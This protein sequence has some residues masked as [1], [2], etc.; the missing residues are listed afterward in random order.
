MTLLH[1]GQLFLS[2]KSHQIP[3][4]SGRVSMVGRR[5]IKLSLC[6]LSGRVSMGGRREIT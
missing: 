4:L 2:M 1:Y 5:E 3:T 6:L